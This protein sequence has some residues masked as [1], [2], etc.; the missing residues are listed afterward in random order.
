M[1]VSVHRSFVLMKRPT[2]REAHRH[3]EGLHRVHSPC[4]ETHS[5]CFSYRTC[6]TTT[7][8]YVMENGDTSKIMVRMRQQLSSPGQTVSTHSVSCGGAVGS[9]EAAGVGT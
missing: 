5:A 3:E 7:T 9:M 1:G 2:H 6:N 4:P 8:A